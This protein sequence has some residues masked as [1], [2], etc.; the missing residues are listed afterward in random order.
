MSADEKMEAAPGGAGRIVCFVGGP[1]A[2]RARR[3]PESAGEIL[4]SEKGFVYRVWPM[5]MPGDK[6]VIYFAF[7]SQEHPLK[8]LFKL[9]EEYSVAA[10]IRG[11]DFGH[12]KRL[13]DDIKTRS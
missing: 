6:R 2:G 8:L 3:V 12:V 13:G 7:D 4:H 5:R 9:W 11:G 10:Q 1:D